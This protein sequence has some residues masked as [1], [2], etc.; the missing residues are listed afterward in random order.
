MSTWR[1]HASK[2]IA[3]VLAECEGKSLK[4]KRAALM[5]AYPYG[6]RAMHPYKIWCD[7]CRVQL[8]LKKVRQPKGLPRPQPQSCKGQGGLFDG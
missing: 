7:E 1:D 3:E 8:G 6:E 5:K 4:E 2:V